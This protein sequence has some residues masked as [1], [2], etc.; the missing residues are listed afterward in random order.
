[1]VKPNGFADSLD[2]ALATD[3]RPTIAKERKTTTN[4]LM[5]NLPEVK[6]PCACDDTL[7]IKYTI[8]VDS[9]ICLESS[10]TRPP[11]A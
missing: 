2:S 8:I 9:S 3:E 11:R 7:I 5:P 4:F 1:M 10:H 6:N